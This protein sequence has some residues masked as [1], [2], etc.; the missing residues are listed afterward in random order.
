PLAASDQTPI[1]LVR[2]HANLQNMLVPFPDLFV[3]SFYSQ[4]LVGKAIITAE[5]VR[6][7]GV[8]TSHTQ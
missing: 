4:T 1:N 8:L 3:L 5:A 6:E 2:D 7:A